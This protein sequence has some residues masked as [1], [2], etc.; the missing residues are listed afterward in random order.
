[1]DLESGYQCAA[2]SLREAQNR[3]CAWCEMHLRESGNPLDHMRPKAAVHDRTR[4]KIAG[5]YWWLTWTWENVLRTCGTCNDQEHKGNYFVLF[6]ETKRLQ[7]S[8]RPPGEERPLLIDPTREDPLDFIEFR[9]GYDGLWRPFPRAAIGEENTRRA[10][11][12]IDVFGLN[13][14]DLLKFYNDQIENMSRD[15]Q[16]VRDALKG[17]NRATI[18]REWE[19]LIG[20]AFSRFGTYQGLLWDYLHH[21][22]RDDLGA[23]RDRWGCEI[24]RPGAV[25]AADASID[26]ERPSD[27]SEEVWLCI[28][29]LGERAGDPDDLRILVLE[30][31]GGSGR[32][33][34]ALT[35]IFDRSSQTMKDYLRELAKE[36][37]L[38]CEG[39]SWRVATS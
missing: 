2:E 4:K 1:M 7:P 14:G 10:I 24:P 6:D 35:E 21:E 31:C 3:K 18:A 26:R 28:E 39:D 32:T 23:L 8:E 34:G 19:R 29:A 38:V 25:L 5:G 20:H 13:K 22:F 16:A 12:T 15:V 17:A 9:V 33:L 36:G 27:I 30:V 37:S 11:E